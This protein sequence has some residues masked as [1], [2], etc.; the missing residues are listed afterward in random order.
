MARN[1]SAYIFS[2]TGRESV[3]ELETMGGKKPADVVQ[4]PALLLSERPQAR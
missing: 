3:D 1:E 4:V 2:S